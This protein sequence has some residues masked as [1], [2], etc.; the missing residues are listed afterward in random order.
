VHPS[1]RILAVLATLPVIPLLLAA[2]AILG[3]AVAVKAIYLWIE[4]VWEGM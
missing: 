2:G 3:A 1:A 4:F